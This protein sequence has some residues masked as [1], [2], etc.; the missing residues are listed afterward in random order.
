MYWRG[1]IGTRFAEALS[2]G[3]ASGVRVRV[4]LDAWGAHSID[5]NLIY[6]DGGGGRPGPLVPTAAPAAADEA[7]PSDPPQGHDRR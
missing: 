3:H 4:L 6:D 5:P 2:D 7:Q 1:E